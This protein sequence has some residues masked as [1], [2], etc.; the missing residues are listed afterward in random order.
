L[1]TASTPQKHPPEKTAVSVPLVVD[2]ARDRSGAAASAIAAAAKS[3][4]IQLVREII[5]TPF[6]ERFSLLI[7]NSNIRPPRLVPDAGE[8]T[9]GPEV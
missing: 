2:A 4:A 1:K 9:G 8:L 3:T 6:P 5:R 7:H